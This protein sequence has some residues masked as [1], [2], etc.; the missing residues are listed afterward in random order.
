LIRLS[1]VAATVQIQAYIDF[2]QQYNLLPARS[3]RHFEEE[4]AQR[5]LAKT[6]LERQKAPFGRV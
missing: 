3:L 6:V 2:L 4:R 5:A 1:L